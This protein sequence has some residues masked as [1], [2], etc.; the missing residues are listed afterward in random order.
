MD[1]RQTLKDWSGYIIIVLSIAGSLVAG[2]MRFASLETRMHDVE[3]VQ[4]LTQ[5]KLDEALASLFRIEG[6]LEQ[7]QRN[8]GQRQYRQ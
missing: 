3:N 8:E 5:A 6:R 2:S 7:Q 1:V 4:V